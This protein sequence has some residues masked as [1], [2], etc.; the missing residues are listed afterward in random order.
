[1]DSVKNKE[2]ERSFSVDT[3]TRMTD[4]TQPLRDVFGDRLKRNEPMAGHIHF[5]IGGP[6]RWFVEAKT[7]E[8]LAKA[9]AI[10]AG[11][12]VP[13]FVLGGGTNVLV[14]DAGF[15]GLVVQVA[16]RSFLVD[17]TT[18]TVG[19]GVMSS[20]LA[21]ATADA[22][23]AGLEWAVSLPGTVGGAI[24]GNAG[25]FGGEM[26]DA[27][28]SVR[29]LRRALIFDLPAAQLGFGYRASV[30][31]KNDDVILSA[32]FALRPGDAA[33]LKKQMDE[34]LAARKESQPMN[35]G[36]AG[37]VFKNFEIVSD[38]DAARLVP[39]VPPDMLAARRVSAGWLVEQA[40][41]KGKNIGQAQFSPVHG[42]FIVN[43]GGAT[44]DE[45]LQL[46]ALAKTR[47][48]DRFG[49]QLQEE[50]EYL[51]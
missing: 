14:A 26:R 24:R 6:A 4:P 28:I 31:K 40:D 1:M 50:I 27:L 34:H 45:V 25:C 44:A 39:E 48:R 35:V 38:A 18:V 13:A 47:V 23:L 8:E 21:R 10:A 30:F 11:A 9:L 15:D 19:A 20:A 43:Q 22:G 32:T 16:L 49:I 36:S 29:V 3:A 46:I 51:G 7:E 12:G 5:R 2:R 37:C 33:A 17:G 42:N 41:L